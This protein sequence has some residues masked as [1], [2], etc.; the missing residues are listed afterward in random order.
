[1]RERARLAGGWLSAGPG[2]DEDFVVTAYLPFEQH[3]D[4]AKDTV[5]A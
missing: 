5:D 2:D 3:A 4:R 1:M